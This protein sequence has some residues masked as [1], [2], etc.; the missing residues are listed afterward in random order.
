MY[1]TVAG[2]VAALKKGSS[3]EYTAENRLFGGSDGY[4]LT[5][6]FPLKGCTRNLEIFGHINRADVDAGKVRFD[7]E[8]RDAN[9]Y[10]AGC[11]AVTEINDSEVKAQFLDGRSEQNYDNTFADIYINELDLGN[12][13]SG[14]PAPQDAWFGATQG[15]PVALPWVADSGIIQNCA[16]YTD[17][18]FKW[19]EDTGGLSWQIYLLDL[20]QR[21]VDELGYTGDFEN[22]IKDEG[23]R[24]I[25][26]C[27]TLPYAW[28]I[29]KFARA[30]P[31]WTVEEY[32]EKLELFLRGEFDIDHKAKTVKFF[33]SY[34]RV[35][36]MPLEVLDSVLD[37][38][39]VA[40]SEDE[41]NCQFLDAKNLVYKECDH[42]MWKYY[43]CDWFIRIFGN[44][45]FWVK[46]FDTM[47][48][49][50]EATKVYQ[51]SKDTFRGRENEPQK[52][53]YAADVDRYFLIRCVRK[54]DPTNIVDHMRNKYTYICV[55]QPLNAFGGRILNTDEDAPKEEIE[56]V[57]V[58]IDDTDE[59]FGQAM[60]LSFAGFDDDETD[61]A[62]SGE[63][64]VTGTNE[65][66]GNMGLGGGVS[67][68]IFTETDEERN[69]KIPKGRA[70]QILCGGE[71][72]ALSEYYDRIFVA[73]YRGGNYGRYPACP[74]V[75]P[76]EIT[77]DWKLS[78]NGSP[79]RLNLGGSFSTPYHN[80]DPLQKV[81][82][83]FL[84][85]TL[86]NPR[87]LFLIRNRR[88]VC[89]KLTATFTEAGMSQLIKFE[90][91]PLKDD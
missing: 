27:N 14:K 63:T 29:T 31:H 26:V 75:D 8:I 6:T 44:Q 56:F 28:G 81:T 51:S 19:H 23:L 3:I 45:E 86:P 68:T 12:W 5:I 43:S 72:E 83:K 37:E 24:F 62:T 50:L 49:L 91:Y 34:E 65:R 18:G 7:C 47:D 57:P 58:R 53:L 76:I 9:F 85:R 55:L 67:G 30:L 11:L 90:G 78:R 22:W 16:E 61:A 54:V 36:Q 1:I 38:R 80:I 21:I 88:Y 74:H 33:R 66:P 69:A 32:F 17:G 82:F 89:Q 46:R 35:E 84:S 59:V 52:L 25:L 41:E 79:L 64:D 10:R 48:Q 71:K 15:K 13:P 4:T 39:T 42:I 2:K 60:F 20:T 70:E 77:P 87:S 40:I 73:W